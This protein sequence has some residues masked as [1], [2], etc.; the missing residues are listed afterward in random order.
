MLGC[1][2]ARQKLRH[3]SLATLK[4]V[5]RSTE[6]GFSIGFGL[7]NEETHVVTPI[8]LAKIVYKWPKK[9]KNIQKMENIRKKWKSN[10]CYDDYRVFRW[11]KNTL[12]TF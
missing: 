5:D 1:H 10:Y 8:V 9:M 3:I 12:S 7:K 4:I 2:P 11:E 6:I